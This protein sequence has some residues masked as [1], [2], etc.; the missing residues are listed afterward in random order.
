MD[1]VSVVIVSF[2]PLFGRFLFLILM[3]IGIF[4]SHSVDG[5]FVERTDSAFNNE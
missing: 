4:E 3:I 1:F 5:M 2:P